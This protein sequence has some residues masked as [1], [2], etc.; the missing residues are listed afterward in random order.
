[1]RLLRRTKAGWHNVTIGQFQAIQ[2]IESEP[3]TRSEKAL[4]IVAILEG[5]AEV[6]LMEKPRKEM[7]GLYR[8]HSYVGNDLP[9]KRITDFELNGVRYHV[10]LNADELTAFQFADLMQVLKRGQPDAHLHEIMAIITI[11]KGSRYVGH[12]MIERAKEFRQHLSIGIAYPC[13]VF[14]CE[15]LKSLPSVLKV[16]SLRVTQ[17]ALAIVE[18]SLSDMDGLSP[19]TRSLILRSLRLKRLEISRLESSSGTRP[20]ITTSKMRKVE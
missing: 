16:N 7:E 17:D 14:F 1:M 2:K 10:E 3:T 15:V 4:S 8:K 11:P 13:L 9:T 19:S 20:T 12:E 6:D 18:G 5:V